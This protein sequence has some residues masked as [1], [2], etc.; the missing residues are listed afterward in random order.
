MELQDLRLECLKLAFSNTD[1]RSTE[2]LIQES[3]EMYMFLVD[4]SLNDTAS[5]FICE[6]CK[7]I[8]KSIN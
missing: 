1:N 4:D 2:M 3:Y 8:E 5:L 6:E 7:E